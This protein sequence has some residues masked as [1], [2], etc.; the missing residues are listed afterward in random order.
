MRVMV[1]V[2][3]ASHPIR[4][5]YC[6]RVGIEGLMKGETMN[7]PF[8]KLKIDCKEDACND[9]PIRREYDNK[10]NAEIAANM[11]DYWKHLQ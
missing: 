11:E 9:C 5:P 1:D 8:T 3:R 10:K 6:Q 7:C 2:L 4:Q